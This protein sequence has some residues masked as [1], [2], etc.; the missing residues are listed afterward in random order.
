[1]CT[2]ECA[3]AKRNARLAEALGISSDRTEKNKA[4]YRDE[5]IAFA[6]ANSKFLPVVEKSLAE[7]VV[8]PHLSSRGMFVYTRLV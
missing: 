7:Y 2:N 4:T 6:R 5:L 3:I 8:C 1:V